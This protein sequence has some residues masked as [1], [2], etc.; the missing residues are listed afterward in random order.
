VISLSGAAMSGAPRADP[1]HP[2]LVV[3]GTGDRINRPSNSQRVYD[4][5]TAPR[6]YLSLLGGDHLQA[7][8][9][10]NTWREVVETVTTEFLQR[11]LAGGP[12]PAGTR[13]GVSLLT[14]DP[15]PTPPH[16]AAVAVGPRP[17]GLRARRSPVHARSR[18]RRG[19]RTARFKPRPLAWRGD[20]ARPS[21]GQSASAASAPR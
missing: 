7:V 6:F 8:V 12:P 4:R 1:S 14:A 16:R 9:G 3:Q 11:Y 19:G 17:R 10:P 13:P 18:I 20:A 15:D 21:G 2:L 5:A